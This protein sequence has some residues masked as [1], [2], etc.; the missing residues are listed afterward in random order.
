[1][2]SCHFSCPGRMH[3]WGRWL[4]YWGWNPQKKNVR[5]IDLHPRMTSHCP[6]NALT[7]ARTEGSCTHSGAAGTRKGTCRTPIAA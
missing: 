4:Q 3:P 1:M 2:T 7:S 6:R 5:S